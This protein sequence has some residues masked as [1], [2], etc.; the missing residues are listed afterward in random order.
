MTQ[1][2]SASS[3]VCSPGDYAKFVCFLLDSPAN[4]PHLCSAKTLREMFSPQ[5]PVTEGVSCGLGIGLQHS[6]Q[7]DSF[8]HWGNN[9]G[10]YHSFFV[11]YPEHG[12]GA[13]AFTN[14]GNGLKLCQSIIPKAIGGEHPALHWPMV[15]R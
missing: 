11:G 9:A 6:P 15:V 3:L 2:M 4:D 13:V 7:G 10:M 12:L 1:P 5:I 8:W 14:S